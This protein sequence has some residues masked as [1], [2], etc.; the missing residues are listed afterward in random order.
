[1]K[2]REKT[3]LDEKSSMNHKNRKCNISSMKYCFLHIKIQLT[4][5]IGHLQQKGDN[6]RLNLY[7]K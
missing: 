1:M 3:F 2:F 5:K 4:D 7:N 6:S